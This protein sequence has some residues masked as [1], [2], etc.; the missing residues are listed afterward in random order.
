MGSTNRCEAR[1]RLVSGE[2]GHRLVLGEVP[3]RRSPPNG[4]GRL[5]LGEGSVG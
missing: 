1:Y 5:V 4:G 3:N 2:A